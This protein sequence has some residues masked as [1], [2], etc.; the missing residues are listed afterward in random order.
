MGDSAK[1]KNIP[2][3][4]TRGSSNSNLALGGNQTLSPR[5]DLDAQLAA[6]ASPVT[7]EKE[8]RAWLEKKGWILPSEQYTKN[9]L[10]DIIF[11]VVLSS[12]LTPTADS[13]LRATAFLMRDLG[14]EDLA[15]SISTKLIDKITSR[16][17]E[18]IDKL[19]KSIS[20]VNNF[21]LATSQQQASALLSLQDSTK[22]QMDLT[23]SIAESSEKLSQTPPPAASRNQHGP[24]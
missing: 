24:L 11:S 22:Q 13:T 5:A 14:E 8:A 6:S 19:D 3:T 2:R 10:A 16:L 17:S 15:T 12:K 18:P 20:S 7:S 1:P 9:K 21:L 23:K 4:S